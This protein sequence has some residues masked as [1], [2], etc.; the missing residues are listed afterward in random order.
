MYAFI[1]IKGVKVLGISLGDLGKKWSWPPV[2]ETIPIIKET[3]FFEK[4]I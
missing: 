4:E 3:R 1:G 2:K